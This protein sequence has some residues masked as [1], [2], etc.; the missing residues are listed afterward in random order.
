[1]N[2]CAKSTSAFEDINDICLRVF[3]KA[4]AECG[5]NIEWDE[6]EERRLLKRRESW[7]KKDR[8]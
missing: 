6:K 1:M 2:I 7:E 5:G 4:E 3:I 8:N